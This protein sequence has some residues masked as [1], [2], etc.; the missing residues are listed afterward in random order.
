MEGGADSG[1][2]G[3]KSNGETAM[4]LAKRLN[5]LESR[6]RELEDWRD[7]VQQAIEDE[8]VETQPGLDLDGHELPGERDPLESL[9]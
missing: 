1:G 7:E 9:G 3:R 5:S 4:S 2:N 6:L 8:S